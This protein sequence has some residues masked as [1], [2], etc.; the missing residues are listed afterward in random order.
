MAFRVERFV[1]W[2]GSNREYCDA[3]GQRLELVGRSVDDHPRTLGERH[4]NRD[5]QRERPKRRAHLC[6]SQFNDLSGSGVA[7]TAQRAGVWANRLSA[8]VRR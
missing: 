1:V 5:L 3:A 6:D 2:V 8:R 4:A 7:A